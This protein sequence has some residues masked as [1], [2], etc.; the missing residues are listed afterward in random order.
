MVEE[1]DKDQANGKSQ[2]DAGDAA[3]PSDTDV[4]RFRPAVPSGGRRFWRAMTKRPQA[5]HLGV[6][7]LLALLGFGAVLQVRGDE[8]DALSHARRDELLQIYDGLTREADRLEE[9]IQDLR[10]DR[11]DLASSAGDESVALEQ[12]E[13]RLRQAQIVAGTVPV[14][15]P[16]IQLTISDPDNQVTDTTLFGAIYELRSA[17]AEAIQIEGQ[18]NDTAVRIVAESYLLPAEGGV[19]VSGVMLRPP[20]VITAIGNPENLDEA[21]HFPQGVMSDVTLDGGD[22]TVT[23]FSELTVETLHEVTEPEHA[24]PAPEGE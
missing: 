11:D 12:A 21:M 2:A 17:G 22:A 4:P 19:E 24:S 8:E 15:G 9:E 14:T 18:G 3:A 7:V 13:E 10:R 5:S 1:Q 6:A 23:Q 20:Y 16:G